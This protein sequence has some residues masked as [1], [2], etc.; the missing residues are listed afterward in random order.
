MAIRFTCANCHKIH[1]IADHHAGKSGRC[2]R[3]GYRFVAPGNPPA[4]LSNIFVPASQPDLWSDVPASAKRSWSGVPSTLMIGLTLG[5]IAIALLFLAR[6][7]L[8]AVAPGLKPALPPKSVGKINPRA[9]GPVV[10]E[11]KKG[12]EFD[13]ESFEVVLKIFVSFSLLFLG[14]I[15]PLVLPSVLSRKHYLSIGRWLIFAGLGGF[16]AYSLA[17]FIDVEEMR[18]MRLNM[19]FHAKPI[20]QYILSILV[21][22]AI[23]CT[24]AA[25]IHPKT[26]TKAPIEL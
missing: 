20:M 3:C 5:L 7:K 21:S 16:L 13:Y 22:G 24:I 23:G 19:P 26:P 25:A 8:V 18:L 6:D 10:A 4:D 17:C 9:R 2:G 1:Q 15:L 12:F 14:S 11:E